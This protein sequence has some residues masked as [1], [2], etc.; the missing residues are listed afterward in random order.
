MNPLRCSRCG[1]GVDDDGDG[2]CGVCAGLTPEDILQIK[3]LIQSLKRKN[4]GVNGRRI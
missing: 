1:L 2:N 3:Y 4:K